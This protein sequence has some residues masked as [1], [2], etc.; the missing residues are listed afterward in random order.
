MGRRE[1]PAVAMR[2]RGQLCARGILCALLC[3]GCG[4]GSTMQTPPPPQ[5]D[6][7][8][9]FSPSSL[10]ITQGTTGSGI[11]VTVQPVN[12]FTGAVQVTLN[13]LPEGVISYPSSPFNVQSGASTTLL[14]GVPATTAPGNTTITAQGV[15]ASVSHSATLALTVQNTVAAVSRSTFARTDAIAALDDPVG[16]PH[17]RHIAYDEANHHLL[18]A[19]RA[20]NRVEVLSAQ[21]GSRVAAVD[22]AGASSADVSADGK[23][24]WIGTVTEQIVGIDAG[25]L[26]RT[27]TLHVAGVEPVPNTIFDRPEEVVTLSGGALMVRLRQA[28]SAKS[29][30]ALS[31]PVGNSLTNL[32]SAAPQVFQNGAGVMARSGDHTRV[33]VCA[34]DT[35]GEAVV[36]DGNA[37]VAV[38]A[39]AIGSGAILY[40][41]SNQDGSQLAV[42][43]NTT[44]GVQVLL[45][46]SSLNLARTRPTNAARG[47][48]FS[49][50]GTK[51]YLA[52]TQ[53][54][55]AVLSALASTDLHLLGQ[56]RDLNIQGV[57]SEIEQADETALVFGLSNRGVSLVDAVNPGT[58][59]SPLPTIA[60]APAASPSGGP[61]LG[62]TPVMLNGQSFGANPTVHFGTQAA[63]NVG[64]ATATQIQATAPASAISGAMNVT[65]Y[66]TDGSVAL[67][68]DAFSYGPQVLEVLPGVG[69][70]AGGDRVA[71]YGYGFGEDA[72]KINV[73]FGSAAGSVQSVEDVPALSASVGLDSSYP[74]PLQRVTVTSPAGSAGNA[75]LIVSAPS[76][77]FIAQQAFQYLQSEQVYPKAGFYK[78]LA[79]DR[80]RQWIYLSNIDHVDVFDLAAVQF[81]A[82]IL[83]PG[84][85]PPDALIRQAALTPDASQLAIADFGAQ[86]VYLM[87]PDTA[88][89]STVK[90]G[91]VAGFAN[92]G[93]VRVAATSDGTMFVGLAEY[94]G[95]SAGCASCLQL[96]NLATSPITSEPAPQPQVSALTS[97]PLL[98]NSGDG[99]SVFLAFAGAPGAPMATWSASA[100][101]QFVTNQ[102]GISTNDVA[103]AADGTF[104]A[105]R[106]GSVVEVRDQNLSLQSVTSP[107]ELEG[108]PQRTEVPGIAL[109]PTGALVY[110]P[111]LTGPPP[112]SAPPAGLQGGVDILDANTGRLRKRVM[113]PEPF[114]ML[115]AD[116]DGLHGKFLSV[117][118]NGQRLF[119]LTVSGLTVVQLASV[120]LGFGTISP[121]SGLTAG[122]MATIRGS[123]FQSETTVTVNGSAATPSFVDMNTLKIT[124]PALNSGPQNLTISNPG[125]ESIS[126]AAA[127]NVN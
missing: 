57:P 53:N 9:S 86:S 93:P 74:F 21:D 127:F 51:V 29:L 105:S 103:A 58:I 115:A 69:D 48:V 17:H 4:G 107:A 22:L 110:V 47:L 62:G 43:L 46:D 92:S 15:S 41:A 79:Y 26:Q 68:P 96:M 63:A 121:A 85:P 94:G 7:A 108:I 32:T 34:N 125:G 11:Q 104:F 31:N 66:F 19:N 24:V 126:I 23:T 100:P 114:A 120:P 95:S 3:A 83:P 88:T 111:F 76:G 12:G 87:D 1:V 102:T 14:L 72:S 113:L 123:G 13:G 6:F 35:S 73:Q 50:D 82:G 20:A 33:L 89:G 112:A 42:V 99:S 39:K 55:N 59:T 52:E 60:N 38:P 67:A 2:I 27:N 119:A 84:G 28:G 8:L 61:N 77:T 54:G 49:S 109:H 64:A 5:P 122:S 36:F 106:I 30:L 56:I 101:L 40:A 70:T 65:V 10:S 78:F 97:A 25:T 37:N 90:V 118:E 45:L 44:S 80:K 81:R 98:E 91:G 124:L 75:E 71:I 116:L 117:D 16:E 18:V